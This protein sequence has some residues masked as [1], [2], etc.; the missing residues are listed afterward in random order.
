[1]D[2]VEVIVEVHVKGRERIG[3]I[4]SDNPFMV[5]VPVPKEFPEDW[6]TKNPFAPELTE[7]RWWPI[8]IRNGRCMIEV[9]PI[10]EMLFDSIFISNA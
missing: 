1:M 2:N 8:E 3:R 10:H 4:R 6:G 5:R 7:H 9:E